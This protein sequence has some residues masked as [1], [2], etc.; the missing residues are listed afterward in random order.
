M[1]HIFT[2]YKKTVLQHLLVGE[3]ASQWAMGIYLS[4]HPF[5]RALV[6]TD[7]LQPHPILNE[8]WASK[9]RCSA[10]TASNFHTDPFSQP[11]RHALLSLLFSHDPYRHCQ[12][13]GDQVSS[14]KFLNVRAP[15]IFNFSELESWHTHHHSE[16]QVW[17]CARVRAQAHTCVCACG[18]HMHVVNIWDNLL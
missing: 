16:K 7:A 1:Q 15:E 14:P 6:L 11:K 13:L 3:V 2:V 9:P 17:V 4:R 5:P 12:S 8:C 18:T 10:C